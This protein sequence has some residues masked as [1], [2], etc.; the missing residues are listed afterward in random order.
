MDRENGKDLRPENVSEELLIPQI[1]FVAIDIETTGLIPERDEIIQIA[2]FRF[3]GNEVVDNYVSF[4]KPKGK[5]PKFIEQLT[6]ISPEELKLAPRL[7]EVL[8]E[9]C[10]FIGNTPLVGHNVNF[11]LS[12]INHALVENGSFPLINVLWDTIEIAR[13]YLPFTTDHKL[14][15]MV[16]FFGIE[17]DNAHRADSDA[18]ATGCLFNAL[19]NYALAHFNYMLNARLQDLSLQANMESGLTEYLKLLVKQQRSTVLSGKKPILPKNELNNVVEHSVSV[20]IDSI[21]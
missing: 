2:A 17:L 1:E 3:N 5:V 20:S 18:L 14:S 9:F 13:M 16:S 4:V 19:T 21:P 8:K 12:F 11:D 6:H 15:T 7:K 10:D